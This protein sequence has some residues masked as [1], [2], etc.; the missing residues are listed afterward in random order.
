VSRILM[1]G[2]TGFVGLPVAKQLVEAG[3]DVSCVIRTG[4]EEALEGLNAQVI[5]SPD[6]FAETPEWWARACGGVDMVIHLAWYAEPGKYLTSDKNLACLSGTLAI[7]QG[8][9][10][11]AVRRFVGIGTCFEYNLTAGHLSVDTPLDPKTPYAAAKV[12]TYT[13]LRAWF[14]QNNTEFLWARLFY[15]YG[16]REDARRLVPYLHAQMAKGEAANLTSG[17]GL[18]DY[19]DVQEAAAQLVGD[20]VGGRQGAT[21][22]CSGTGTTIRALAERIADQ[23]GRRDLLN[24]GARPDNLTDPPVVLGIRPQETE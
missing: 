9:V 8:A 20:A 7:A 19:M 23:Y 14:A 12:A 21:N 4:R 1:T 15:L 10:R 13:M 16:A 17:T 22:I 18:K 6:L 2:A 3:H 11:A 5:P 24:F